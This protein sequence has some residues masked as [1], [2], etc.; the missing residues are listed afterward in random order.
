ML[1]NPLSADSSQDDSFLY[2]C[3][4]PT[5]EMLQSGTHC[6]WY[7]WTVQAQKLLAK[8]RSMFSPLIA[9]QGI[10][11]KAL[12][13]PPGSPS[14]C[15]LWYGH[16]S[17]GFIFLIW[18]L[19]ALLSTFTLSIRNNFGLN[20]SGS[21]LGRHIRSTSKAWSTQSDVGLGAQQHNAVPPLTWHGGAAAWDHSKQPESQKIKIKIKKSHYSP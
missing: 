8:P 2:P 18:L 6:L 5:P 14:H 21:W 13:Q 12:L 1:P 19:I 3:C 4:A 11:E 15:I 9:P 16:L 17:G 20:K 10:L 7:W